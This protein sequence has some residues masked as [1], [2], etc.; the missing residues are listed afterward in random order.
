MILFLLQN[1][2]MTWQYPT[3]FQNC[4]WFISSKVQFCFAQIELKMNENFCAFVTATNKNFSRLLIGIAL[5]ANCC[6][7]PLF[8]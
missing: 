3:H 2:F 7:Y 8:M 5:N 1:M 6:F 4:I